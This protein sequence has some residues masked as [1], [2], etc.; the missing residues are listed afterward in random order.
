MSNHKIFK[1]HIGV[2]RWKAV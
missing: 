1:V 2:M